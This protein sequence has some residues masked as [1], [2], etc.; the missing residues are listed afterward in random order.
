[1]GEKSRFLF[2]PQA[3]VKRSQ[4][5][6][7]YPDSEELDEQTQRA[8]ARRLAAQLYTQLW[9]QNMAAQD[10]VMQPED[11][12]IDE[13]EPGEWYDRPFSE[14]MEGVD[15]RGGWFTSSHQAL[16]KHSITLIDYLFGHHDILF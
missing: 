16:T 9:Q 8:M 5:V 1:M 2:S 10:D 15:D 4:A 7:T 3:E 13:G 11:D 12:V 6:E 14:D